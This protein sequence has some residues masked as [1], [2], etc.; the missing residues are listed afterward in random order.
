MN[1]ISNTDVETI[2][3]EIANSSLINDTTKQAI[4]KAISDMHKLEAITKIYDAWDKTT[5]YMSTSAMED[6]EKVLIP[7]KR[8]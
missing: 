6:I 2:L 8:K 7:R 4:Y 3:S 5:N 1:E